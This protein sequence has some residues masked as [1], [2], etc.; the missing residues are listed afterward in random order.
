MFYNNNSELILV[1]KDIVTNTLNLS[2]IKV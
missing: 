2:D 1:I